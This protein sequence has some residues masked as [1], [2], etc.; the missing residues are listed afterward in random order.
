MK[1]RF[2]CAMDD[3]LPIVLYGMMAVA[4]GS[5]VVAVWTVFRR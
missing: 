5:T 2:A 4:V 1:N 3:W